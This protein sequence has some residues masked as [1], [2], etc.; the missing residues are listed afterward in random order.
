MMRLFYI[1]MSKRE[2][3]GTPPLKASCYAWIRPVCL[4]LQYL[5]PYTFKRP[6]LDG[7]IVDIIEHVLTRE[8]RINKISHT[9]DQGATHILRRYQIAIYQDCIANNCRV[10]KRIHTVRR[11]GEF[12]YH[13]FQFV[14]RTQF[15]GPR[16]LGCECGDH[17][18]RIWIFRVFLNNV[19]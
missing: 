16:Q 11:I 13:H 19:T 8:R 10:F 14:G 9:T 2:E 6:V 17:N 5:Y 15:Y 7:Q 12:A 1:I 18:I 3:N 4:Q